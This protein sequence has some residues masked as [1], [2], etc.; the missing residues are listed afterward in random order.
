MPAQSVSTK[1]L[2]FI[3][4]VKNIDCLLLPKTLF[5]LLVGYI[6]VYILNALLYC[7]SVILLYITN[8]PKFGTCITGVGSKHQIVS[9]SF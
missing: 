1:N 3:F 4:R 2:P 5:M 8:Y 9:C 7:M 6:R